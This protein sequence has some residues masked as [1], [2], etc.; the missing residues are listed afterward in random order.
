MWKSGDGSSLWFLWRGE[1]EGASSRG[2]KG[3]RPSGM[4]LPRPRAATHPFGSGCSD[5]LLLGLQ[6]IC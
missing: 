6:H 4:V 5:S 2:R 3:R 1:Q